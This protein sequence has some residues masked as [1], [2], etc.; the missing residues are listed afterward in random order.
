MWQI[1]ESQWVNPAMIVSLQVY[2][3]QVDVVMMGRAEPVRESGEEKRRFLLSLEHA[4]I[5]L[6]EDRPDPEA[7]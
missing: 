6:P 2:P 7:S 4:R 3:A 1:S 5:S